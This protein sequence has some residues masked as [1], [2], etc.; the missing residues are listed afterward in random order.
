MYQ[1]QYVPMYG[2]T[3]YQQ[4]QQPY[5]QAQT[6]QQAPQ[7]TAQTAPSYTAVPVTSKEEALAVPVDYFSLGKVMVDMNHGTIYLKRFNPNTGGSDFLRFAYAPEEQA[8]QN[9]QSGLKESDLQPIWD[10]INKLKEELEK[11]KPKGGRKNVSV[12]E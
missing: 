7:Q 4:F 3:P 1:N 10:E 6:T 5:A 11:A 2:Q 9:V 12:D 8:Q